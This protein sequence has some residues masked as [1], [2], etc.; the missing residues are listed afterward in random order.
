[1]NCQNARDTFAELLDRRTTGTEVAPVGGH[2]A[3]HAEA[4][5]HLAN[6]PDCQRE[7]AAFRATL[8]ALDTLPIPAPSPALRENFFTMLAA[9]KRPAA[10]ELTRS[11]HP[12]NRSAA[13]TL[14]VR[15]WR[16]AWPAL[17]GCALGVLGFV[18]GRTSHPLVAPAGPST[19][20]ALAMQQQITQ[21]QQQVAKM[22]TLVSYSLLQQQQR[23]A[24]DRLRLVLTSAML[25]HPGD[26][27]IND[28]ISSLAFDPSPNV[29]LSALDAL[30]PHAEQEV[31][32]ASVVASLG[33]EQNPLVQMSMIDFLAAANDVEAKPALEKISASANADDNVRNAARRALTQF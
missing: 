13:P 27:V 26:K 14:G 16:W 1:M 10:V 15:I 33:R 24:N 22:G 17:A 11:D 6:C 9:E 29:R 25:E 2:I 21:L 4:R 30:Y 7:F 5:A 12:G 20:D 32:R 19:P 31:V 3:A 23:P 8:D 18:L 28:L